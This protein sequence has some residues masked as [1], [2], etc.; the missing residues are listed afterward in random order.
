MTDDQPTQQPTPEDLQVEAETLS[1]A[2]H[3]YIVTLDAPILMAELR[4]LS[5]SIASTLDDAPE[6]SGIGMAFRA[7][8]MGLARFDDTTGHALPIAVTPA[9]CRCSEDDGLGKRLTALLTAVRKAAHARAAAHVLPEGFDLSKL[10]D[11]IREQLPEGTNIGG[12]VAVPMQGG[13]PA[14]DP[15]VLAQGDDDEPPAPGLY[16]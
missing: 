6:L 14:G 4:C 10:V 9:D 16:L 5:G 7:L 3:D 12:V 15:I 11:S 1:E 8:S 13:K 2:L